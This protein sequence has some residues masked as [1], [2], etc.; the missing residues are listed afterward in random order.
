MALLTSD[1]KINQA[2]YFI[3]NI[4]TEDVFFFG[5]QILNVNTTTVNSTVQDTFYNV[6][7]NMIF[8]QYITEDNYNA[9]IPRVDWV[10][11][12]VYTEYDHEAD[13]EGSSFYVSTFESSAYSVFKCLDNNK[14][15][16]STDKP[17]L[18]E[19][20]PGDAFYQTSDGYIWKLMY[21]VD[22]TT[23]D[24]FATDSYMP[25]IANVAVSNSAV[26]GA[27]DVVK[28]TDAGSGYKNTANGVITT[29]AVGGNS[30][31][32]YIDTTSNTALSANAGY[33]TDC[34]VYITSG[35]GAGQQRSIIDYGTEGSDRFIIVDTAFTTGLSTSSNILI[36]PEAIADGDGTGFQGHVVVD[37]SDFTLDYVEVVN[38]GTDYTYATMTI[39][40][41]TAAINTASY[42]AGSLRAII[43]PFG[44]HGFD[45]Q[46][47]LFGKY[48]C[49][50]DTFSGN[51][52]PAANNDTIE[53][54]VLFKIQ[55]LEQQNLILIL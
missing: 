23:Y 49:I 12:T 22:Q 42:S 14:G 26:S 34:A 36:A 16:A 43:P 28:V 25:F 32:F 48:V 27:I 51:T 18:S 6:H 46:E 21:T 30:R 31:K 50:T 4:N 39:G 55:H 8:G 5:G 38:S 54:L 15:V 41:N 1:F 19:T 7:N 33:Y 44:G 20:S 17:L 29:V 40:S 3:D 53:R 47:E 37:T 52:V 9:M 13:L 10:S 24:K 45:A 35:D 2:N 11:N